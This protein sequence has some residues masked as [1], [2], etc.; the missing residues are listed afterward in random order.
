MGAEKIK[1]PEQA[2]GLVRNLERRQALLT[3]ISKKETGDVPDIVIKDTLL[4]FLDKKYKKLDAEGVKDLNKRIFMLLNR[5]ASLVDKKQDTA[6]ITSMYAYPYTGAR[7]INENSYGDFLNEV[8]EIIH[9]CK[10]Y[11]VDLK[12][13]TGMQAGLG[14]PKVDDLNKLLTWV[15]ENKESGVDLKSITGMQAGLGVP[16]VDDLNKLLTEIK[17]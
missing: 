2:E 9:L 13:I 4:K 1:I 10:Q 16:K 15:K 8:K 3:R 14:V 7:P 11:G 12:S 5:A 6:P 17:R